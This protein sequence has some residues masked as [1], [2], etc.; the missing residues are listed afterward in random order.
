MAAD[1]DEHDLGAGR[2][3]SE[4]DPQ[5]LDRRGGRRVE[6]PDEDEHDAECRQAERREP[7]TQ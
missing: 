7:W 3:E 2:R 1:R 4:H 6:A 5:R